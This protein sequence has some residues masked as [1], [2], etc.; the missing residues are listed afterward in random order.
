MTHN[1]RGRGPRPLRIDLPGDV[2]QTSPVNAGK[3][4]GKASERTSAISVK[5]TRIQAPSS[6]SASNRKVATR[7]SNDTP[8]AAMRTDDEWSAPVDRRPRA[9]KRRSAAAAATV[10]DTT[11]QGECAQQ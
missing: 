2:Q 10:S 6:G 9:V 11:P 4:S 3:A 8:H 5:Q 1:R 7:A